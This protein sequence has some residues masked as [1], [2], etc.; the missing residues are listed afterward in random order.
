MY[1]YKVWSMLFCFLEIS[2]QTQSNCSGALIINPYVMKMKR[3]SM[4]SVSD[5]G[6]RG[7]SLSPG[8]SHSIAFLGKTLYSQVSS[9]LVRCPL[10]NPLS[11]NINM[12][13]LLTVFHVS[14]DTTWENLFK[15]QDISSLVVI[16]FI[17]ITCMFDKSV[18]F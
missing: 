11:P 7:P 15:H 17:L 1:L 8:S 12:H 9:I 3:H 13:I 5:S 4:V 16:S 18:I 2:I 6:S 10:I 14:Y